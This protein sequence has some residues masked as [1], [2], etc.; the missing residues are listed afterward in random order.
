M[1]VTVTVSDL[2]ERLKENREKH[3]RDYELAMKAWQLELAKIISE[4]DPLTCEEY[5]WELENL[6]HEYPIS[7]LGD[8]DR[9]IEMFTMSTQE[10]MTIDSFAFD[11]YVRDEWEWKS[12]VVKNRFYQSA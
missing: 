11:T 12:S 10:E 7:Y 5:P 9:A 3:A 8:Y 4:I 1:E 6:K 2:L